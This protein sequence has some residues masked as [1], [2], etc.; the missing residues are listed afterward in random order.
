M[1]I[2]APY[3]LKLT[4]S[5]TRMAGE[6]D[7]ITPLEF[8]NPYL[9]QQEYEFQVNKAHLALLNKIFTPSVINQ[10]LKSTQKICAFEKIH[11]PQH[12][13]PKFSTVGI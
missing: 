6:Q 7:W 1:N 8:Y 2:I 10:I 3:V 13:F 5:Q 9:T 4:K 11:P 12:T